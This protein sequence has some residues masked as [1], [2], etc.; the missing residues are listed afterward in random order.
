ML[1]VAPKG[2]VEPATGLS[3]AEDVLLR[4]AFGRFCEPDQRVAAAAVVR[5][6]QL[7]G[8]GHW[9][10]CDC[11]GNR[12]DDAR[13]PALVPVAA[14]HLRRH[15]HGCWAAHAPD[16]DF[17]REPA[18]QKH[19]TLT[20]RRTDQVEPVIKGYRGDPSDF[21]VHLSGISQA[22]DRPPLARLLIGLVQDAGLLRVP[23]GWEERD[24]AGQYRELRL[25]AR[26]F[27]LTST[28]RLAPYLETFVPRYEEFRQR[29]EAVPPVKFKGARPHGILIVA[30]RAVSEGAIVVSDGMSLPVAGRISVFGEIEGHGRIQD[31][32]ARRPPYL[33]A[34]LVA[35]PD[36]DAPAAILRAYAHPVASRA[37]LLLLDSDHERR[38]LRRLIAL[39]RWLVR[40]RNI[41]VTIEKPQFDIGPPDPDATDAAATGAR[42]PVIPD[43]IVRA[44]AANGST[45]TVIVETM[46]YADERYRQRKERIHPLMRAALNGAPIVLHVCHQRG[47]DDRG[48]PQEVDREMGRQV[49]RAIFH[50][51]DPPA[52]RAPGPMAAPGIG[53]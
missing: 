22:E 14:T 19:A 33:V 28:L 49:L 46:G 38:T 35:R 1:R 47:G 18:E 4:R 34:A 53:T 21:R 17:F 30:A 31:A 50:Q 29:I 20:Y 40:A 26:K 51:I 25:A 13:P 2:R 15:V 27:Q 42:P 10:L 39:Q 9:I 3:E 52:I 23:P 37:H 44:K 41:L 45:A 6:W 7:D 36:P 43:F 12:A 32:A 5:H 24:L 48:D 11:L 8:P 16:C